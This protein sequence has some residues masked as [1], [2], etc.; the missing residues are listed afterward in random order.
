MFTEYNIELLTEKE[1]TYVFIYFQCL[2]MSKTWDTCKCDM[3]GCI[4]ID[5]EMCPNFC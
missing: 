5:S 4:E 3:W 2:N 1:Y